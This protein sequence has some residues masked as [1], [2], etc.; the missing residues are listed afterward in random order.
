MEA[1]NEKLKEE[2]KRQEAEITA[3]NEK[4]QKQSRADHNKSTTAN[5]SGV[6]TVP[7]SP[8][9]T[10]HAHWFQVKKFE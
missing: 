7:P 5:T 10:A 8:I 1:E 2:N 9:G 3:L 6:K 4:L